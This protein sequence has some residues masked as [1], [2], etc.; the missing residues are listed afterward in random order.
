MSDNIYTYV[1]NSVEASLLNPP[2]TDFQRGYL[3]AL[4]VLAEEALGLRMDMHPF[5]EA[6]NLCFTPKYMIARA[7]RDLTRCSR[8]M[9][10]LI[11]RERDDR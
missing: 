4:L 6:H 3:A 8:Q 10:N 9:E 7:K 5:R 1:T 11:D 2:D